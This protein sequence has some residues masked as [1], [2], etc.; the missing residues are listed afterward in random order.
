MLKDC[1]EQGMWERHQNYNLKKRDLWD[2]PEKDG[3][4]QYWKTSRRR[5]LQEIETEDWQSKEVEEFVH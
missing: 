3:L 5:S 4:V 2:D 1:E